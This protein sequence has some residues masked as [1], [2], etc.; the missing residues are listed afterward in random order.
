MPRF[1]EFA[2][3][4]WGRRRKCTNKKNGRIEIQRDVKLSPDMKWSEENHLNFQHRC[5]KILNVTSAMCICSLFNVIVS[6][7]LYNYR[8]LVDQR[9][10]RTCYSICRHRHFK[11]LWFG[12]TSKKLL[13]LS[14]THLFLNCLKNS[15]TQVYH[16]KIT[17]TNH[18]KDTAD[19]IISFKKGILDILLKFGDACEKILRTWITNNIKHLTFFSVWLVFIIH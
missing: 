2:Q 11:C 1:V 12:S 19:P 4:F 5:A 18:Q 14:T 15:L 10:I 13:T 3:W 17:T 8:Q 7:L 16:I 6:R 9:I